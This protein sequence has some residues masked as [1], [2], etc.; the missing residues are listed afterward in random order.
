MDDFRAAEAQVRPSAMREVALEVTN[1]RWADVG[2]LESVKQRLQEAVEWPQRHADALKRLG[3][4]ARPA[5]LSHKGTAVMFYKIWKR[6]HK[7]ANHISMDARPAC[8]LHKGT[9]VMLALQD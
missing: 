2:G 1:V 7:T 8:L 5:R 9:A 4:K 6:L 3:A